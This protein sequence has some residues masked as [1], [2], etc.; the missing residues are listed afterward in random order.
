[1]ADYKVVDAEQLEADLTVVAD[2]IREKGG[3][4]EQLEFPN[5]MADAVMSIQSDGTNWLDYAVSITKLFQGMKLPDDSDVNI[6]FGNKAEIHHQISTAI[7]LISYIYYRAQGAKSF[8]ISSGLNIEKAE[9]SNSFESLGGV[10]ADTKLKTI[11]ISGLVHIKPT[12]INRFAFQRQGL[13]EIIGAFDLSVCTSV[14]NAFNYC[15]NL[16]EIRFVENTINL[17]ISFAQSPLLSAESIQSIIDGLAT[18]ETTQTLTFRADV[19][20][21]LTDEQ[22][23]TITSKNWTLA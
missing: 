13:E 22:I 11:D 20:A 23:A 7:T 6:S 1:M 3:T 19:K 8:K 18:V 2:A 12:T 5:G 14:G 4:S 15:G 16:K 10:D 9:Y 21:K 17:S